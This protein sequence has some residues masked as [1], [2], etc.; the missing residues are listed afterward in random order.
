MSKPAATS[1]RFSRETTNRTATHAMSHTATPLP[2]MQTERTQPRL[3]RYLATMTFK[4]PLD[5]RCQR[6]LKIFL[7]KVRPHFQSVSLVCVYNDLQL[8]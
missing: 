7:V 6:G 3:D 8:S 2:M 4:A 5:P 1:L